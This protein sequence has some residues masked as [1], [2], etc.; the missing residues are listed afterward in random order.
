MIEPMTFNELM[1]MST[2]QVEYNILRITPARGKVMTHDQIKKS[3][4]LSDGRSELLRA[5]FENDL[6]QEIGK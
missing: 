3:M 1:A 2:E 5:K 4:M 6:G